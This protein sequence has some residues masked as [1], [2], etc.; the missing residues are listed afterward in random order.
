MSQ[1]TNG[2]L[3][4]HLKHTHTQEEGKYIFSKI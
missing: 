1:Q 4:P 3:H 2:Q